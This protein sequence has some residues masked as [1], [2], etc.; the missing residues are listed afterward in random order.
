MLFLPIINDIGI[1]CKIR[2]MA[3]QYGIIISN[4]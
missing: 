1:H 3:I 4:K 2:S